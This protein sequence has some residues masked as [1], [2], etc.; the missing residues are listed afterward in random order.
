[1]SESR[2]ILVSLE[3][4]EGAGKSTLA[5]EL[6]RRFVERGRE[7]L[8]RREPGGTSLGEAVRAVVLDPAHGE[9][10]PWSEL[11]LMLAARAQLV[12]EVVEPALAAG[13]VVLLDRFADASTAYQGAGRGLGIEQVRE[14]NRIATRGRMPHRTLLLDLDPAEG[15]RRQLEAPDRMEREALDFHARVRAGYLRLAKDEPDRFVVV[16]AAQEPAQVVR[17]AWTAL[18]PLLGAH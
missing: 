15:R 16:D 8:R 5:D 9:V 6:E 3:G 12:Q 18:E 10:S 14:L 13:K 1:V 17:V 7:V 11:F 4:V 2:G